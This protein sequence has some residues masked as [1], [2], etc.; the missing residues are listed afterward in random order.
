MNHLSKAWLS[1]S[2]VLLVSTCLF[3]QGKRWH[4]DSTAISSSNPDGST[5]QRAFP[6]LQ[7]ALQIA[8][9]GDSVWVAKGTYYPTSGLDQNAS[10]KIPN[11]VILIGGF[12]GIEQLPEERNWQS[13]PSIL[14]GNIGNKASDTD[15]SYH[16][17]ELVNVDSTSLIDGFWIER[18]VST[19]PGNNL[20]Q[21]GA[22]IMIMANSSLFISNPRIGNCVFQYNNANR[23]GAISITTGT[24][25][26]RVKIHNCTF[27]KNSA[28]L[29][30]AIYFD[31]GDQDGFLDLSNCSFKANQALQQ[32]PCIYSA[33][34]GN[35]DV[36]NTVFE[37]N[38]STRG[39]GGIFISGDLYLDDC[40]FTN[41]KD[42]VESLIRINMPFKFNPGT[43]NIWIQKTSF[44]SNTSSATTGMISFQTSRNENID[45]RLQQCNFKNNETNEGTQ[46]I[47]MANFSSSSK[48]SFLI[49][50][51]VFEQN[52]ILRPTSLPVSGMIDIQ[53]ITQ[54]NGGINGT[55][56]NCIF[57]KNDRPMNIGHD[58]IG[59]TRISILN[60]TFAGNTHGAIVKR[61][62]RPSRQAEVYLQNNI[63]NDAVPDL[64]SI[65]QTPQRPNLSG[66][67]FNHNLF[68]APACKTSP[69][70][71]G[72]GVGNIFGQSPKFVDSSSV[73]GLQLAPGS[74]AINAGAWHPELTA[75]DL[76]GQPRVQ[77]C[78]VDLG[79]YESPSVLAA[80]DSL[81]AEAQIRSTPFNQTLG[82]ISIQQIKG[83]FPPYRLLWEN[84]DTTRTR[85]NLAAGSY[86][87]TLS[88]QQGCFKNYSFMVPFTTS[89]RDRVAQGAIR[90]AP[91]PA[92]EGQ[93]LQLFYEG[94]EPGNWDLQLLDMT[95]KLLRNSR[96]NL[97]NQGA[98]PVQ[99]DALPKGI[100]LLNLYKDGRLFTHKFVIQ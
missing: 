7:Q 63:F 69:D 96:I 26:G 39:G 72:C 22:G 30:A 50:Q 99:L 31:S 65:L 41:N 12:K 15:N 56:R 19:T 16:V 55:I 91:N 43:T 25:I 93:P 54:A 92:P 48:V 3:A 53:N 47:R 38:E 71:L 20:S 76:A 75:L 89:V 11:G 24:R 82:Q 95:G 94:I 23:G 49:D 10:F 100:Y 44:I 2:L 13:N 84:G 40:V 1:F 78:K 5:W 67:T 34:N 9:A 37:E 21:R 17:L 77:D 66:F 64:S 32:G 8:K 4:V 14:S 87:L 52:R 61:D 28:S 81:S 68:R 29:G 98:V 46:V 6:D 27:Y 73:A 88:D 57:L 42:L 86:T 58:S 79:A 74:L 62:T 60:S 33:L 70:T 36:R 83:G 97:S 45:L 35:L 80:E 85:S 90:L 51:C 59:P 18:G